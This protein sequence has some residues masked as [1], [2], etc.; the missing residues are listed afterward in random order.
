MSKLDAR[1]N[2]S[3]AKMQ[4]RTIIA[5]GYRTD[6]KAVQEMFQYMSVKPTQEMIQEAIGYFS[7]NGIPM[8]MT[9]LYA[10][11]K[12]KGYDKERLDLRKKN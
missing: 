3:T 12:E 9:N 4:T 5:S 6:E 2:K 8:N 10:Y 7:A 11:I 1:R